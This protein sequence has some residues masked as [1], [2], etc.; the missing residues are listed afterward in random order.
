MAATG[1][2]K[3]SKAIRQ[4]AFRL[5]LEHS[6]QFGDF[7]LSSGKKSRYYL[8]MKST[9]FEPAAVRTLAMLVLER[10]GSVKPTF[11]GGMELGA[12]PL[13]SPIVMLARQEKSWNLP[14]F[15]V[16]K[17]PKEHGT[18]RLVEGVLPGELKDESVVILDDVTT[19]G[20]S[21][22]HAVDAVRNE[23]G[24]VALVLSIVDRE[25]GAEEFFKRQ[26]IPFDSLFKVSDLSR[27]PNPSKPRTQTGAARSN[28]RAE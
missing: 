25:E 9:M 21:V 16:R 3:N 28:T 15:F 14:G 6:F 26:G 13:I 7:T 11:I 8:D 22:M 4:E 24:K 10:I 27:K 2:S 23:G 1:V 20:N 17:K 12:V 18:K 5:I 19:S